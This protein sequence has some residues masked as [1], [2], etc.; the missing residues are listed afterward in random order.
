[1]QEITLRL[2]GDL[3]ALYPGTTWVTTFFAGLA[4]V[5]FVARAVGLHRLS[6]SSCRLVFIFALTP[7]YA[8]GL[9]TTWNYIDYMSWFPYHLADH[10]VM[11]FCCMY[12]LVLVVPAHLAGLTLAV[13]RDRFRAIMAQFGWSYRLVIF[14]VLMTV[15]GSFCLLFRTVPAA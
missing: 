11:G 9:E 3:Q 12:S 6:R 7:I 2:L 4:V 15:C 14:S 10:Q 13:G 8:W 1:M 5:S